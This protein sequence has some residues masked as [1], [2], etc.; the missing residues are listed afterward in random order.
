MFI[1]ISDKDVLIRKGLNKDKKLR[2][3]GIEIYF[4]NDGYY[5]FLR[6]GYYLDNSNKN[7]RLEYRNY[8][9]RMADYY[10]EIELYV[11]DDQKGL[12]TFHI[13][14]LKDFIA[15]STPNADVYLRD[16]YLKDRYLT[17]KDGHL[18]A[19]YPLIVNG[20]DYDGHKLLSG[21]KVEM[22]SFR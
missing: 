21:D 20:R 18:R 19:N 7:C 6:D 11:Y 15:A 1:I 9:I 4:K 3:K 22:L 13:F 17:L 5:L 12:D 16:P 8:S 2:Y 10:Y 14:R